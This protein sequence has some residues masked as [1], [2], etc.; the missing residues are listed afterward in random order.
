MANGTMSVI[1]TLVIGLGTKG[2]EICDYVARRVRWE[3]GSLDKAP[4]IR[5]LYVATDVNEEVKHPPDVRKDFCTLSISAKEYA[6]ILSV[7]GILDHIGLSQWAHIDLLAK[8]PGQ[9]VN[10]GAGNIR[11]V[12]RLAFLYPKNYKEVSAKLNGRLLDLHTLTETNATKM[13]GP[14]PDGTNPVIA[15]GAGGAVRVMVVGSLCGGTCSGISSDF[16]F[17]LRKVCK[18]G[19]QTQAFF[20]IPHPTF[21]E[22]RLKKNAYQA[23]VELNAYHVLSLGG[24]GQA[25]ETREYP[26][27]AVY[28]CQPSDSTEQSLEKLHQAI[29]DRIFLNSFVPE[30]DPFGKLVDA[31]LVTADDRAHV[32]CS[33]GLASMEYPA[34]QVIE[35]CSKKLLAYALNEWNLRSIDDQQLQQ[36]LVEIGLT[37]EELRSHLLSSQEGEPA[38]VRMKNLIKEIIQAIPQN[39]P[40]ADDLLKIFRNAFSGVYIDD[41]EHKEPYPAGFVRHHLMENRESA[42]NNVINRLRQYVQNTMPMF[43]E[44]PARLQALLQNANQRLVELSRVKAPSIADAV[45]HV[46]ETFHKVRQYQGSFKLLF[47][48]LRGL[49]VERTKNELRN[50]LEKEMQLRFDAETCR[51]LQDIAKPEGGNDPGVISRLQAKLSPISQRAE[52]LRRRVNKLSVQMSQE[53]ERLANEKPA[54]NGICLF[55]PEQTVEKA[56]EEML[57]AKGFAGDSLEQCKKRA[58]ENILKAWGHPL[59]R[60]GYPAK[61]VVPEDLTHKTWLDSPVSPHEHGIPDGL[62]D[63]LLRRATE[64]FLELTRRDVLEQWATEPVEAKKVALAS[65]L[66][67]QAETFGFVDELVALK[68]IRAVKE[69]L[70][71]RS[72][73]LLPDSIHAD[74]F[75]SAIAGKL[76]AGTQYSKSSQMYRVVIVQEKYR[77]GLHGMPDI[78]GPGGLAY[79]ESGDFHVWYTRKDMAWVGITDPELQR[80]RRARELVAVGVLLKLLVP[81]D[82]SL[83]F[84]ESDDYKLPLDVELAACSVAYG[85]STVDGSSIAGFEHMLDA[86][87]QKYRKACGSDEAFISRLVKAAK[88]P[89]GGFI[90]WDANWF[91]ERVEAYCQRDASLRAAFDQ[92]YPPDEALASALWKEKG[93]PVGPLAVP[94]EEAGYYCKHCGALI[95]RTKEEA[96]QMGWRCSVDP[97]HKFPVRLKK[98]AGV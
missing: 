44:G 64:P 62:V 33:F 83:Q 17:L 78:S 12:G 55:E 20:T 70:A 87:I 28:V 77:F 42:A 84:T 37:W 40:E 8:I 90:K 46:D 60:Y 56:F 38:D 54:V 98:P 47:F 65:S 89:T 72:L 82:L 9:A 50:A 5:F 7:P 45:T 3:L 48:W 94:C 97:E 95:G 1:K 31:G 24:Y 19:D 15:F 51:V 25:K 76:P 27:D 85:R 59:E 52:E 4:W 88:L 80:L 36:R 73:L 32:F 96:S 61:A 43:S 30:V 22:N 16:G 14:L 81:K 26:Y 34:Q 21:A 13:R 18:D 67:Q 41:V 58:A 86:Y 49:A 6:N 10:E 11:M 23:L 75:K 91:E 93:D 74:Q 69:Y 92:V 57:L 66:V 53:S 79:A 29:A 71:T 2:G 63:E 68:G 39:M 35:S